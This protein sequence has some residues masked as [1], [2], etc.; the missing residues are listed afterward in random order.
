MDLLM[1]EQGDGGELT[2]T[3]GDI[4]SDN[5]I[6]TSVYLSLFSGGCWANL[7]SSDVDTDR[8]FATALF[9]TITPNALRTIESEAKLALEW[10]IEDGVAQSVEVEAISPQ[11][12]RINITI[13]VNEPEGGSQ[14][15]GLIW[16]S[17]REN[18]ARF[19]NLTN[20]GYDL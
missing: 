12:N 13:T 18:V 2:F 1:I 16:D 17:E 14:T 4:A 15:F 10:L 7:F 11:H 8:A 3:G 20:G 19:V 5:G 9:T 6:Y